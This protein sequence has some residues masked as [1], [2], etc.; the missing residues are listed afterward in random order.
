MKN[1]S[2]KITII[3][4]VYNAENFVS[5]CLDSLINQTYTNIEII[6]INDG[7]QDES[8]KILKQYQKKDKRIS[9]IDKKNAG[10]SAARNDGIKYATGDYITFIDADDWLELNAIEI[11]Y[12]TL[13][14][15]NVDVVRGNYFVNYSYDENSKLETGELYNLKNKL[16]HTDQSDFESSVIDRLL[17]GKIPCFIWLLLIKKE[18]L[19]N[20]KFKENIKYMEDT[21][22]YNELMNV[23]DSIYFL[24]KPLY[25]YFNNQD[26]CTRSYD[27]YI[28]N[29][30]NVLD[31]NNELNNIIINSK[32]YSDNRIKLMNTMHLNLIMNY[33]YCMYKTEYKNK[34]DLIIEI[35]KILDNKKIQ[36]LLK[37]S[38]L[39]ILPSHQNISIRFIA[40]RKFKIL[41]WFYGIR[42]LLAKLK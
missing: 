39:K 41:F 13:Q 6:C 19:I 37:N 27:Y 10:V 33:F 17:N 16:I 22:F 3:V 29:M 40:A 4:P 2:K 28:R 1:K 24:D 8:L 42:M 30:Y 11:L 31:V 7:S 23:I 38:N 9:I 15:Y 26:S 18:L 36:Q 32:F 21:I 34:K 5:K 25:H 20:I 12:D 35:N 14:K